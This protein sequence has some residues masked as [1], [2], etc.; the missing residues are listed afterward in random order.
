MQLWDL[1]TNV[2]AHDVHIISEYIITTGGDQIT[3]FGLSCR[4][5]DR[6]GF[7]VHFDLG[8]ETGELTIQDEANG[9]TKVHRT[10]H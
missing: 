1:K 8:T 4:I 7:H 10:I 2:T 3:F 9:E 6:D 5:L